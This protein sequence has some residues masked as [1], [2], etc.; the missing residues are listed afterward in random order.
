MFPIFNVTFKT[1]GIVKTEELKNGK[2][3]FLF[4]YTQNKGL[5]DVTADVCGFKKTVEVDVGK[6]V[7]E[8]TFNVTDNIEYLDKLKINVNVEGNG[9]VALTGKVSIK[10]NNKE[11]LVDLTN[12]EAN[13][14]IP[15]L[16]PSKYNLTFTYLGSEE[17]FKAFANTTVKHQNR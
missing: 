12:G 16:T 13:L 6:L 14:E 15:D 17:Y 5:Y 8:L 1:S 2:S 10:L 9:V 7:S 3:E 4:N 11:Y